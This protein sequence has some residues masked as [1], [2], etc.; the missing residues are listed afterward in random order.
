MQALPSIGRSIVFSCPQIKIMK[1][2]TV[3]IAALGN[4]LSSGTSKSSLHDHAKRDSRQMPMNYQEHKTSGA[5]SGCVGDALFRQ[6]GSRDF[7]AVSKILS[8]FLD[9]PRLSSA[10]SIR[11]QKARDVIRLLEGG[12]PF[13][14]IELEFVYVTRSASAT[15]DSNIVA[16]HLIR[17]MI[18]PMPSLFPCQHAEH[19]L[20]DIRLREFVFARHLELYGQSLHVTLQEIF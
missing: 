1:S 12:G 16:T 7:R 15:S 17:S 5:S 14:P 8:Q 4:L 11:T 9:Q 19:V 18:C 20:V 13:Q 2:R 3:T 10:V 6:Q